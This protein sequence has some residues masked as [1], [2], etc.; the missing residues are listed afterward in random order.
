MFTN[1]YDIMMGF[2][3]YL[4]MWL[5]VSKWFWKMFGQ[6]FFLPLSPLFLGL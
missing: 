2:F 4:N 1:L 3:N 6:T 5:D